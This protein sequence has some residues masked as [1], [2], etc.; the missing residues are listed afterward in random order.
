MVIS[1]Y[2]SESSCMG[3]SDLGRFEGDWIVADP[4][5]FRFRF[6]AVA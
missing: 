4:T 3:G 5:I 2:R 1:S 6:G